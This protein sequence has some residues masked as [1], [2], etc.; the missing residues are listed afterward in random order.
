M[1]PTGAR[2]VRRAQ[3][4]TV[5]EYIRPGTASS[6]RAVTP[7]LSEVHS[8]VRWDETDMGLGAAIRKGCYGLGAPLLKV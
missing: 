3:D 2:I 5:P 6:E 1:L 8:Y 4:R 7:A